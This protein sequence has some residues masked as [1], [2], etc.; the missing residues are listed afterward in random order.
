M[1]KQEQQIE[2]DREKI[3]VLKNIHK[4]YLLGVEGVS[5]LRGIDLN[6]YRGDFLIIYGASGGGK[7]SLLNVI[8]TIDKPTKGDLLI[9]GHKIKFNT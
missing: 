2:Y 1:T 3:I 6:V 7:T 5:A 4:T 8:G 9:C